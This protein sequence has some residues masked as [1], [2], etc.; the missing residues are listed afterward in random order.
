MLGRWEW[1]QTA[2]SNKIALTPANTGHHMA[3]HFDQRGRARF[4][5]DDKLVSAAAFTLRRDGMG[6]HEPVRHIITYRGYQVTQYYSVI[7]NQLQLQDT[8]GRVATHSYIRVVS[9]P[10]NT[11]GSA[12]PSLRLLHASN[13]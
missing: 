9:G 1:Q 2:T 10:K 13:P 6:F 12:D 5:Q 8:D 3:V 11:L 7:G 4:Y